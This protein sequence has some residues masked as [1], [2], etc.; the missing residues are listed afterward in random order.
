[1][2]VS[3]ETEGTRL[4]EKR[5]ERGVQT[6]RLL[7]GGQRTGRLHGWL[8]GRGQGPRKTQAMLGKPRE[9]SSGR[10]DNPT[11]ADDA[12]GSRSYATRSRGFGHL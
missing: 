1:M 7:W 8:T 12:D 9:G 5:V 6:A 11:S 2:N 10:T 4:R 3:R